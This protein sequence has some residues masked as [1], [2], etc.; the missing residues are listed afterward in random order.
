MHL[1]RGD[2]LFLSVGIMEVRSRRCLTSHL[3]PQE[4]SPLPSLWR[5]SESFG[6]ISVVPT[7]TLCHPGNEA[8]QRGGRSGG[9]GSH[10]G[11]EC[12]HRRIGLFYFGGINRYPNTRV[13]AGKAAPRS[14]TMKVDLHR[15]V[16][17]AFS[18]PSSSFGQT[19]L[20]PKFNGY[21]RKSGA[22]SPEKLFT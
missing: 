3:S 2:R 8:A 11:S 17:R 10:T 14:D 16:K 20:I 15:L 22:W 7:W 6:L 9:V 5:S 12:A 18:T 4:I 21:L 19:K 1:A 13:R